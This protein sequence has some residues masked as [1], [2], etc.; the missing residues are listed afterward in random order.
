[1]FVTVGKTQYKVTWRHGNNDPEPET[2]TKV[3]ECM[4][5][6]VADPTIAYHGFSFC[7]WKD[8]Y[9]KETGRKLSMTE[10]LHYAFEFDEEARAAFWKAYFNRA[11]P[12]T[13][14][15]V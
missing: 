9:V 13:L 6:D 15:G 5:T 2:G 7:H 8:N 14:E 12:L 11:N 4:I 1:M 3:C 10:A